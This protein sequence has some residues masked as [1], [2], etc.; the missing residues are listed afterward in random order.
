MH[1]IHQEQVPPVSCKD[2]GLKYTYALHTP[3]RMHYIHQVQVPLVSC[4]DDMAALC[5][6]LVS[7]LFANAATLA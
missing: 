2:I 4:K 7:A 5:K 6:C 3:I 1:Y